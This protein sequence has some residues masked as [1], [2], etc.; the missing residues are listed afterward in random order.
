M[1]GPHIR[2]TDIALSAFLDE[3][4]G[5]LRSVSDGQKALT[6]SLRRT[7]EHFEVDDGC[8][9]ALASD[10]SRAEL[11]SVIPRGTK[12][13]LE[14]LA[15]FLRKQRLHIPPNIIMAPINRRG[16]LWATL[17]LKEQHYFK[18]YDDLRALRQIAKLVSEA[19][20]VIDWQRTIEVR[21]RIDRKILE[22]LRPQDLF[23]QILHGL[24]SLTSYDHSS[25]LLICDRRE[26]ALHLVAEQIAWIKGKSH[27]IGLR[28][29]L[30]DDVWA[31]M[32][33][34]IVYGFDWRDGRW[35]EWSGGRSTP[36]AQLLDYNKIV[37]ASSS[38]L[39]ESS[40]LCAPLATRDGLL[41]VLKVAAC[42][43]GSFSGYEANL[44]EQFMP[45]A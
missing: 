43:P 1:N 10:G 39:R 22:Q 13:D 40:I 3:L 15:A 27:R 42:Y 16:R 8:I 6:H 33:N 34:N 25:A 35:E 18:R 37:E 30:N 12:W 14:L 31:L 29:P 4:K 45:L 26:G 5:Y 41:G 9:A 17:A 36:L 19:I 32:D 23:Y 20:E 21:A 44:V 38:D 11:I 2:S 7:C 28:L 24:R